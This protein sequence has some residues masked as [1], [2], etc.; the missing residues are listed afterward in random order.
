MRKS[1]KCHVA[2]QLLIKHVFPTELQLVSGSSGTEQ[3]D[4]RDNAPDA[5]GDAGKA[6]ADGYTEGIPGPVTRL[7]VLANRGLSNL[8]QDLILVS[9]CVCVGGYIS[10]V[11]FSSCSLFYS[12]LAAH[13]SDQ[14]TSCEFQGP[15]HHLANLSPFRIITD[16][17]PYS[18]LFMT[19][20]YSSYPSCSTCP[21]SPYVALT[22][23]YTIFIIIYWS[24]YHFFLFLEFTPV[25]TRI[26]NHVV[27]PCMVL[28]YCGY[29][30]FSNQSN[31]L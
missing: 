7:I 11:L 25:Y 29:H 8:I 27:Y 22:T 13:C 9:V 16:L 26:K 15:T 30:F 28:Q 2:L 18:F 1:S 31:R 10:N 20:K 5:G 24:A 14:R 4:E 17:Q 6:A 21:M 23:R 3:T 12:H 19:P